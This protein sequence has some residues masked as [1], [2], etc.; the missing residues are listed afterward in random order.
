MTFRSQATIL[1]CTA[2]PVVRALQ[3]DHFSP[4]IQAT[5]MDQA[6]LDKLVDT[7]YD[8]PTKFLVATFPKLRQVAYTHL[9]DNVW[10]PLVVGEVKAPEGV[11][12][13]SQ[14]ARLFVSDPPNSV[15][16]CYDMHTLPTGLLSIQNRRAAV[17]GYNASWL[18]VNSQGDLYFTGRKASIAAATLTNHNNSVFRQDVANIVAGYSTDPTEVY[19]RANSGNPNARVW[20][21][22]GL[23]V[24]SFNIYWGN[25]EEGT[26]HG[27]LVKGPRQNLGS[28][29][30]SA[31]TIM[32]LSTQMDEVRGVANTG[33]H[34]FWNTPDGVYGVSKTTASTVTNPEQ[35]L[36]ATSPPDG[37]EE[38]GKKWSPMSIAFDGEASVYISDQGLGRLYTMPAQTLKP[39]NL[40]MFVDAPGIARV[41][42][43]DFHNTFTAL[44]GTGGVGAATHTFKEPSFLLPFLVVAALSTLAM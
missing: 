35:G 11:A 40:T 9:P 4:V 44:T 28:A 36:I 3:A 22:S 2:L 31:G 26:T 29:V 23:A 13:D 6:H 8:S 21:P 24:D 38:N 1:L 42:V 25:Q 34:L 20:V 17:E 15:I 12:V 33:T 5:S 18:A 7:S 14:H 27:S 19:S 41:A 30:S 43:C 39:S 10:R 16:L 32:E 37:G